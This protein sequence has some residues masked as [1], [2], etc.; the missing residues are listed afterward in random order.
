MDALDLDI[1]NY[2]INDIEKFF[3]LHHLTTEKP[4]PEGGLIGNGDAFS[5][6]EMQRGIKKG[7]KYTAADVELREAEIREQLLQSGHINKRMKKDLVDFLTKAKQWLIEVRCEPPRQPTTLPKN[8][9]LDM[10]E[11]PI[12]KEPPRT[13]EGDLIAHPNTQYIHSMHSDF[14]PGKM[15]PLETRIITKCL[16]VDTRFRDNYCS[17]LSTDYTLQLPLKLSKVVSL[18]LESV[19]I[20]NTMYAISSRYGN[21]YIYIN[22]VYQNPNPTYDDEEPHTDSQVFILQDGNYKAHELIKTLNCIISPKDCSGNPIYPESMF[23]YIE[24]FLDVDKDRSGTARVFLT[25]AGDKGDQIITINLD[26]SRNIDGERDGIPNTCRLGWNL[27]FTGYLYEGATFYMAD[28]L[29]QPVLNRCMYLSIDDFNNHSNNFF[30]SASDKL[31]LS[32]NIIAK[33]SII[34]DFFDIQI[35]N[36][37]KVI[38]EPRK[39]FGPVDIQRLKIQLLDD[40][41]RIVDLNGADYSFCLIIKMIY[42]L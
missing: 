28:T 27:G 14:F 13:R 29:I 34:G 7:S 35:V 38:T 2:S 32:P 22:L 17:T 18:Q 10:F 19:D 15:N 31:N 11:Y 21:N 36:D 39:Y 30:I 6:Y 4:T 5:A 26:F 12:S 16:S 40:H 3:K 33:V 37:L 25:T 24:F 8:T 20:P 42:D 41:G 23:S 1:N 9:R